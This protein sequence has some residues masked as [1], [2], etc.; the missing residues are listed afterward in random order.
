[1]VDSLGVAL[2]AIYKVYGFYR[3]LRLFINN[4][5]GK[6]LTQLGDSAFAS[7]NVHLKAI[8]NTPE[9]RDTYL[10]LAI[11]KFQDAEGMFANSAPTGFYRWAKENGF[12]FYRGGYSLRAQA[13]NKAAAAT[14]LQASCYRDLRDKANTAASVKRAIEYFNEYRPA[15][16]EA[17]V[18]ENTKV[19]SYQGNTFRSISYNEPSDEKMGEFKRLIEE[20]WERLLNLQN[21]NEA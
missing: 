9:R 15:A 4:D 8:E 21:P 6:L 2:G 1:M 12:L 5:M 20:Q 14:I 3:T 18:E 19:S 17:F 11:L 7:A 13:Y 16:R 10:P